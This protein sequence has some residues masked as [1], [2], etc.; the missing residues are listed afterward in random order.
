MVGLLVLSVIPPI[1]PVSAGGGGAVGAALARIGHGARLPVGRTG[2]GCIQHVCDTMYRFFCFSCTIRFM[3]KPSPPQK[4]QTATELNFSESA[5]ARAIRALDPTGDVV[6][7]DAGGKISYSTAIK[8]GRAIAPSDS[9]EEHARAFIAAHLVKA[10]GYPLSALR[11][12][13]PIRARVGRVEKDKRCDL[14]VRDNSDRIHYFM[15]IK[16]PERWHAE[17]ASAVEGQLFGLAPFCRPRPAYLVYATTERG[18]GGEVRVLCEIMNGGLSH[19]EW[20]KSGG[21]IA[22][23]ELKSGWSAPSKRDYVHGGKNDLAAEVGEDELIHIRRS[24]HNVLW[25]GGGTGDTEVF[26]FLV[27]LLLA[28]IQDEEDTPKGESYHV[29]DNADPQTVLK[30][31]NARYQDALSRISGYSPEKQADEQ[32]ITHNEISE[33]KFLYAINRIERLNFTRIGET[34]GARDILGDFFEGIMRTGFKQSK[35]QFF[36]HLNIIR[37]L[38]YAIQLDRMAVDMINHAAPSLPTIIDPSAGS[39]AFL[40]EAMKAVTCAARAGPI[41]NARQARNFV[42][43][44]FDRPRAHSWAG[45][46]CVGLELNPHLGRAAQANMILHSDGSSAMLVGDPRGNGL[47]PLSQYSERFPL[48]GEKSIPDYGRPVNENF[49]VVLTNPPFSVTLPDRGRAR[50]QLYESFELAGASSQALFLERWFQLLKPGGRLGAVLP[51]SV[52]DGRGTGA[53]NVRKFLLRQFN[54][55]GIVGLP[56]DAFYP[57]TNTKTSLLLAEKKTAAERAVA[58][59]CAGLEELLKNNGEIAFAN[60]VNLGYDRTMTRESASQRNDLYKT[61]E[62]GGVASPDNDNRILGRMRR[63][64]QWRKT[65]PSANWHGPV[66]SNLGRLDAEC[67]LWVSKIPRSRRAPLTDYFDIIPATRLKTEDI[68]VSFKYCEIGDVSPNNSIM[69]KQVNLSAPDDEDKEAARLMKK[70]RHGD[71]IQPQ[72]GHILVPMVRPYLGKI[73]IVRDDDVYFTSAF[74]ILKPRS[75]NMR[76]YYALLRGLLLPMLTAHSRWGVAYPTLHRND[77]RDAVVDRK[78]V[79]G[80]LNDRRKHELAQKL[81]KIFN[82]FASVQSEIAETLKALG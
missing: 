19:E 12:E 80:F 24:L 21:R 45:E 57:Y 68:P 70:I 29:Q 61:D 36:T 43:E 82:K 62:N 50:T 9:S 3:K 10:L 33:D 25:G 53:I 40:V 20:E 7:F 59:E 6:S 72:Q 35:G 81:E 26:N 55:Q 78:M 69:P 8:K 76:L 30:R 27:R 56:A 28:K 54:V 77:L 42:R 79:E 60:A 23:H 52:F 71:I 11:L 39:G 49:D 73:L 17:K 48:S 38:I 37:F 31:V 44:K 14:T 41:R 75:K 63:E 5:V 65:P 67:N 51:N 46:C 13:E 1:A 16:S 58:A 64:I 4:S 18:Q 47:A 34:P 32:V 66:G 2:E 15:E 22:G 74:I